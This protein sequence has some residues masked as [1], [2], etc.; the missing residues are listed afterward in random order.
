MINLIREN[1]ILSHSSSFVFIQRL[2]KFTFSY[3]SISYDAFFG[4]NIK[5]RALGRVSKNSSTLKFVCVFCMM[6]RERDAMKY[7]AMAGRKV[8]AISGTRRVKAW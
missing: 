2:A 1:R 7:S 8:T 5:T 4:L 3:T 6:E